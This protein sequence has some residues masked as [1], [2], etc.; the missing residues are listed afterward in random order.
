MSTSSSALAEVPLNLLVVDDDDVDREKILRL[1]RRIPLKFQV[2]EGSSAREAL[3]LIQDKPFQCAILDYRLKDA[4]GSELVEALQSHNT[5]PIPIIMVSG[6]SDERIVANLMREGIFD[7]LPKRNLQVEQLQTALEKG[8]A[9]AKHESLVCEQR[10]RF[11]ELAEGLPHLVWTCLPDGRCDFLNRRWCEYTGRPQEEQLGFGWLEHVHPEDK[12]NLI[13]AWSQCVTSGAS[14]H[15]KFRI[16]RHDGDYR[17]FDTRATAQRDSEGNILRWLGS[18]TDITDFELTRQALA[19][20]EQRFHAAFD[21][22]PLGMALISLEGDIVQANSAF[23][24]L[25]G[26]EAPAQLGTPGHIAQISFDE[27]LELEGK[28]LLEL[29]QRDTPFV[30]FEKRLRGREGNTL[31]TQVSVALINKNARPPCYL[32][33]FYDLSERKRYEQQLIK[34]AHYDSLTGLG[35]RA[36][37]FEEIE[38]L[39]QRSHRGGTP[40]AL[41]FG[42]LDHFKQINDG[43]GHEAGD[44][45]LRTVARRLQK[46]LRRGDSVSRLGGDE[47]VVLLQDVNRF[48][49][50]ITV[51]EKLIQRIKRPVR[52]GH[53]VVHVGMSF[54]IALY[55]T[56]GDN[57]QTL[58]RNADSALYDAKTKGRGCLQLYRKELTEY[59]HNR[60]MLDADLRNAIQRQ[61][62]EL[63]YQPVIDLT[64]QQISSVEALIR[65]RHP[66]RGTVSPDEFIPYAQESGLITR[67]GEWVLHQACRQAALWQAQGINIPLAINVSARQFLQ[68]NLVS[69]IQRAL[70]EHQLHAS[71]LILEITEQM[72]LENTQE[73][74][75][76]IHELKAMGLR[77]SLDDFGVGYSSLSYILRFAPHYLKIDR[78]FVDQIG[79]APEQDAMVEAI[80]GLKQIMP[81]SL[82]AEGV[83]TDEQQAFLQC[84]GCTLAQGYKYA[85]PLPPAALN[86]V[87]QRFGLKTDSP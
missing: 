11:N 34:L 19:S 81:M 26:E 35:N 2:S 28:Y 54:G 75:R 18:N 13:H 79:K 63:Y 64:S 12:D 21:Y 51:A 23:Y 37:L 80:I 49:A 83:E 72:F 87:F 52:L 3:S 86:E 33:Q 45:L 77:I 71:S 73:N 74:I 15:V 62:F 1:L 8:L 84:H 9:W 70:E 38:F 60:L 57:P 6:N 44:L 14:L 85:R 78:S 65:W 67:I 82:V 39:I 56:D 42:D 25:L 17:W 69:L 41:L 68:N 50:V 61:E 10:K 16:R 31:T 59:V 43:L 27:E 40:F 20:S 30:Q 47:F 22:A 5:C 48:E 46:G 53:N 29:Q 58:L 32:Y 24:Q 76:Q 55:P 7:Y 36:K 4:L 66:V